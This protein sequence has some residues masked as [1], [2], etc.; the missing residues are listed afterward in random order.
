MGFKEP[1]LRI[2]LGKSVNQ[3]K[4]EEKAETPYRIP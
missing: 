2:K 3:A 1:E 4:Q